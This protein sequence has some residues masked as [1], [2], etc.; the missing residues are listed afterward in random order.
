MVLE[1]WRPPALRPS[2]TFDEM[3]RLMDEFSAGW[4]FRLWW[5][6]I[7]AEEI[8][9]APSLDMYEKEDSFIVRAELAGVK[10]EDIDISITGDTLTIKG[11]RKASAEVKDEEYHRCEVCYGSF[12]RSITMP[13]AVDMSKIEATYVDGI[14][15]VRLPKAKEAVPAKIEIK[16]K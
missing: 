1:R 8:V 2:R 5:R 13:A 14:L 9:W 4:P 10:K 7:P 11:E 3:E 6:R 15:E 16:A 12:S